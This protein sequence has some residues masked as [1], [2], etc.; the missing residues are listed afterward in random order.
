MGE[1]MYLIDTLDNG[2]KVVMENISYVN[3][4]SIGIIVDIGSINEDK[5]NYGVSHFI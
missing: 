3:S 1:N 5:H 2:I 4:I